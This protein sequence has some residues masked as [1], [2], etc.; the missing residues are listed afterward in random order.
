MKTTIWI[1]YIW[2][3]KNTFRKN[4]SRKYNIHSGIDL[5]ITWFHESQSSITNSQYFWSHSRK[6]IVV[7]VVLHQNNLCTNLDWNLEFMAYI[8]WTAWFSVHSNKSQLKSKSHSQWHYPIIVDMLSITKLFI[9]LGKA[10]VFLT[11][12]SN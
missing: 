8:Y 11:G 6:I 7:V 5:L 3:K 1:F 9:E 4:Y 12:Y 2:F 10:Y